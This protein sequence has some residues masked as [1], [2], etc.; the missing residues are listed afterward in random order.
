M[1]ITGIF[2]TDVY[3]IRLTWLFK[4]YLDFIGLDT[5]VDLQPALQILP[6]E[7]ADLR[8]YGHSQ[9]VGDEVFQFVYGSVS[10]ELWP[11]FPGNYTR[12]GDV[13]PLL[14]GVDDKFVIFWA[15]DE[16]A[17]RFT[18]PAPPPAA[19]HRRYILHS[20]GYYKDLTFGGAHEVELLPFGA[21]S[22][23]PYDPAVEHYPDDADHVSYQATY[24]TRWLP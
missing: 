15:G 14:D 3:R 5:T 9:R 16:V 24:N 21:M 8:Y 17:L 22:N 20:H 7:T 13:T 10:Q 6:L 11:A 4:T 1:D 12:F 19:T 18:P 23:Y 2:V